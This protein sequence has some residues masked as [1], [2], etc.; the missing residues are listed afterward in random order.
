MAD[1]YPS[2]SPYAYVANNPINRIDPDG[3]D[4]YEDE[5][6]NYKWF[7]GSDSHDGY[8][9]VKEGHEYT[10]QDGR[11]VVL[12]HKNKNWDYKQTPYNFSKSETVRN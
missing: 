10:S 1:K 7:N 4:W 2:I 12:S 3:K 8:K 11:T 5:C 6:G 9:R